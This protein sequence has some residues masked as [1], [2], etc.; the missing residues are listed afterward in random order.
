MRFVSLILAFLALG[1]FAGEGHGPVK[2]GLKPA[3]AAGVALDG[4]GRLWWAWTEAGHVHVQPEGGTAHRVNAVPEIVAADGENRP[5]LAFGPKGEVFVSWTR[6]LGKPY[7]G[8]V[9]LARSIDGGNSFSPPRTVNDD[10]REITHRF[11]SMIVDGEGRLWLAWIDKRDQEDAKARRQ[12]YAGAAI[13]VSS[14]ADGGEHFGPDRKLDDHSCECCRLALTLDP[15]GRAWGLWR[16]VL[17]PNVRDHKLAP[18]DGTSA[19]VR[20]TASDW[21]VDAC[22]HHGPALAIGGDGVR[23]LAWFSGKEGAAGLFYS[24]LDASGRFLD[25]PLSFG[26]RGA[27]HPALAIAGQRLWL[28][29]KRFDGERTV[30]ELMESGDGGEHWSAARIVAMTEGASDQPQLLNGKGQVLLAW[31][32]ADQGFMKWSL[33]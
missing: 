19:P 2:A 24:R 26:G 16:G 8:E 28:A 22:P 15:Q 17:D 23:H 30:L 5:K 4:A 33:P 9:R 11:E 3:L 18:L 29:W 32:S 13:Y 20:A 1:A 21:R 31:R 14:S 12:P 6:P 25:K 7:S 10:R 27:A